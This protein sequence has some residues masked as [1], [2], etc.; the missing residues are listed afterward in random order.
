[1][2]YE[3]RQVSAFIFAHFAI[4]IL[5]LHESGISIYVTCFHIS[6]IS[7]VQIHGMPKFCCYYALPMWVWKSN[8]IAVKANGH[9]ICTCFSTSKVSRV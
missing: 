3:Y 9:E 7:R 2:H 5:A 1:M 6:K 4:W 8:I